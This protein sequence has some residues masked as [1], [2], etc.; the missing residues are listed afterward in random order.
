MTN[1]LSDIRA[2]AQNVSFV[3]FIQWQIDVNLCER[4]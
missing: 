1:I 4:N 2:D 3:T